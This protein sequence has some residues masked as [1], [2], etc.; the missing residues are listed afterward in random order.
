MR[1]DTSC[2]TLIVDAAGRLL[3]CH[4]TGTKHW[5]IPKGVRD[6]GETALEAARRELFEE[7]GLAIDAGRFI[8]LGEFAYR[9]DKRLHLF[10]VE[11]G[12]ELCSL[13]H[14]ACTS[15]FPHHVTG[16]PTPEADAFRWATR[17]E[18]RTLCWPRMAERLLALDW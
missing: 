11:A 7:A 6:A 1:L 14:L 10:R 13:D 5:D 17:D 18:V 15:F 12:A 9:R 2:G 8:D 4:V 3:L 16:E